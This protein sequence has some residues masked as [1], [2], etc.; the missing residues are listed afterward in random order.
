LRTGKSD[1][2][3]IF[4]FCDFLIVRPLAVIYPC[5]GIIV[6]SG[7]KAV[8]YLSGEN[9]EMTAAGTGALIEIFGQGK[10]IF[11]KNGI[12]HTAQKKD[13]NDFPFLGKSVQI[14]KSCIKQQ[15]V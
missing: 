6:K 7:F 1:N 2:N 13:M 4:V 5:D 15:L 14:P 11:C 10:I 3:L 8:F 12:F 9:T